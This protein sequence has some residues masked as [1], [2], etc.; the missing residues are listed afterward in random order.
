MLVIASAAA[1]LVFNAGLC[2]SFN[3]GKMRCSRMAASSGSDG[4]LGFPVGSVRF[5]CR[6][7]GFD[8]PIL[9]IDCDFI[10]VAY[11]L[12]C[13][14][15]LFYFLQ[16]RREVF[17]CP[18]FSAKDTTPHYTTPLIQGSGGPRARVPEAYV[19]NWG[20]HLRYL[21]LAVRH[22]QLPHKEPQ[23]PS[24]QH[25]CHYNHYAG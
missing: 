16:Y 23:P 25:V 8:F 3:T 10:G 19:S 11:F 4:G 14:L 20:K 5:F 7:L 9:I 1:D 12:W 17:R 24:P 6:F 15:F 21:L 2:R 22:F 18:H 13:F